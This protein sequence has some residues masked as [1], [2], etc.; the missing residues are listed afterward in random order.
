WVCGCVFGACCGGGWVCGWGGFGV[1]FCFVWCFVVVVCCV[2]EMWVVFMGWRGS[3]LV[4]WLF[5]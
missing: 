3:L 2:G 5:V 1:C 4:V